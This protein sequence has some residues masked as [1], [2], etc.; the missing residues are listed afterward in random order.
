[1]KL[2]INRSYL[3]KGMKMNN[4]NNAAVT[5]VDYK[6][7]MKQLLGEDLAVDFINKQEIK[8]EAAKEKAEKKAK[9]DAKKRAN[10]ESTINKRT[11]A[12][13]QNEAWK[14]NCSSDIVKQANALIVKREQFETVTLARSNKEL[15]GIMAEIYTLFK[16]AVKFDCL[17]ETAKAMRKQ[18]TARG[19]RVQ[20]NTNAITVFVRYVFNSDRKRAYNYAST[21]MAALQ[22]NVDVDG[23]A[24]F[25][26]NN[27]GVEECKK[28]FRKSDKTKSKEAQ[29]AA[30]AV[31]VVDELSTMQAQHV[32]TLENANVELV[33]N[34]QFV[35]VVARKCTDGSLELL[36]AVNKTTAALQNIVIKQ[37]ALQYVETQG[38]ALKVAAN[39]I[40]KAASTKVTSS[41]ATS[42]K[43]TVKHT[44]SK[45][46]AK[47]AALT[48]QQ[49][50][51][52]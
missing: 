35:F 11:L 23:L 50:E 2:L 25:I 13:M 39:A 22:A 15:Y 4:T 10:G 32:V 38:K 36:H 1:M 29:L 33:D 6:E 44:V 43:T 8:K 31:S 7:T 3:M 24:K 20:C 12:K 42:S 48:M 17:A 9:R 51:S 30:A 49:L 45:N 19:V 14:N 28:Q 34:T 18:L 26:E 27:N 40:N 47:A 16:S 5:E 37:L 21:L 52:K 46:A 41:K